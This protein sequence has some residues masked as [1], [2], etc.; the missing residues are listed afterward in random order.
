MGGSGFGSRD[1]LPE[2]WAGV[3]LHGPAP[4]A[5]TPASVSPPVQALAVPP[6]IR[7][8]LDGIGPHACF[9]RS[10][11]RDPPT[12]LSGANAPAL[13]HV[14][15]RIENSVKRRPGCLLV[16]WMKFLESADASDREQS[17]T[18]NP[19]LIPNQKEV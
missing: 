14:V 10:A 8:P 15:R 5:A 9:F 19:N 13:M 11:F 4:S 6:S 1:R 12:V 17:R 2:F 18:P 16:R 7:V 3:W